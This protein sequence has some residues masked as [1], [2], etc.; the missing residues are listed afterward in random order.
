MFDGNDVSIAGM[1][2]DIFWKGVIPEFV[3]FSAF[4][5]LNFM[6]SKQFC[7]RL[8]TSYFRNKIV[9]FKKYQFYSSCM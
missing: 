9:E 4:S 5:H 2:F 8:K 3:V 1:Y 6:P 7:R